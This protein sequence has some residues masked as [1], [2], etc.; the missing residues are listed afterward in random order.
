MNSPKKMLHCRQI[1]K[2]APLRRPLC[3]STAYNALSVSLEIEIIRV[4]AEAVV[5]IQL[6]DGFNILIAECEV[7]ESGVLDDPLLMDRLRNGDDTL[8][9]IPAQNNLCYRL[10]V[11]LCQFLQQR[12]V[13]IPCMSGLQASSWIS[14]SRAYFSNSR[15]VSSGWNSTWSTTGTTPL[16]S[17]IS[18]R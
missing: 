11:T 6:L 10:A 2:A 14:C 1:Q 4:R 5:L 9:Q 13:Q 18:S 16:S 12:Q 17:M 15:W 3:A 7:E 8:L